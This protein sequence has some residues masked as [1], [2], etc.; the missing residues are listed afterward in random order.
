MKLEIKYDGSNYVIEGAIAIY[1][2]TK[3]A[4]PTSRLLHGSRDE[5]MYAEFIGYGNV[6]G[7]PV[8]A[9]YLMTHD[10]CKDEDSGNW[11]WEIGLAQGR[12]EIEIDKLTN[13]QTI[14]LVNVIKEG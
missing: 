10:D 7:I 4:V 3:M 6:L 8:K 5:G 1:E 14:L 13:D 2:E 12:I 9:S 11:D